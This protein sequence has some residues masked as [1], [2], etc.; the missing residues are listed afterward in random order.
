M[1]ARIGD[2]K[3]SCVIAEWFKCICVA[4]HPKEKRKVELISLHLQDNASVSFNFGLECRLFP[5][6]TLMGCLHEKRASE[7]EDRSH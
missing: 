5:H 7:H 3:I 4:P 2:G 1:Q 6:Q